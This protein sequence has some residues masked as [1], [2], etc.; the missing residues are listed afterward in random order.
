MYIYIHVYTHKY[1]YIYM[2]SHKYIY[3]Y[4]YIKLPIN[5]A[6]LMDAD[7]TYHVVRKV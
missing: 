7:Y 6:S 2:Y 3:V 1:I 4:I 5:S